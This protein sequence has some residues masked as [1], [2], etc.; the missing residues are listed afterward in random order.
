VSRQQLI[1]PVDILR[2]H[3]QVHRLHLVLVLE[4]GAGRDSVVRE[5]SRAHIEVSY[6][7]VVVTEVID[8]SILPDIEVEEA[9]SS[10]EL[11]HKLFVV[12][13]VPHL[14][15]LYDI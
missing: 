14:V 9:D 13:S 7:E 11:G 10:L 12:A 5:D 3:I 1:V 2:L 15:R 4:G 8:L 6:W